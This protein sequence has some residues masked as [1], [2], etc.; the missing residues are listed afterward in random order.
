MN[1]WLVEEHKKRF[2][3]AVPDLFTAGGMSAA[4]SIVEALKKTKGDT[5]VD[6]LI[7]KMEGM[8]F[9][10]PKGKMKFREKDHQAYKHYI[11]STL[12]KQDG[13]DYPVPVLER[14]LTMKET[15]PQFKINRLNF[16]LF[17]YKE[18]DTLFILI[19]F[20]HKAF[21][22]RDFMTHL[23]ETKNLCVSFGDHH[24]I[25]DVNLTVQKGKLISIIGPMVLERQHYSIY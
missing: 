10:T 18:G 21:R 1:D 13:V 3:G 8:E 22:G 19:S 6:T 5:D 7:K 20:I 14:E 2:N 16:L 12:K 9:E 4:I 15:E 23:L 11:L 25:K 17:L 24:V